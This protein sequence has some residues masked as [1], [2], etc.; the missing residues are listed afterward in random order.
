MEM[1]DEDCTCI[2]VERDVCHALFLERE[3]LVDLAWH[4]ENFEYTSEETYIH[5]KRDLLNKTRVYL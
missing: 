4:L 2:H 3:N 1:S 5:M